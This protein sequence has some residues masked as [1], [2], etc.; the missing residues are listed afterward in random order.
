MNQ[1]TDPMQ[2]EAALPDQTANLTIPNH[3]PDTEGAGSNSKNADLVTKMKPGVISEMLSEAKTENC[4]TT[5]TK[6]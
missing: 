1:K 2:W 4:L 6:V 5:K 3:K